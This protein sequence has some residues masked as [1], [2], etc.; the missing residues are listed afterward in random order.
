MPAA[1]GGQL[2]EKKGLGAGGWDSCDEAVTLRV[3]RRQGK[4][5]GADGPPAATLTEAR[6]GMLGAGG[7]MTEPVT[8]RIFSDYV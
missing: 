5:H 1:L 7:L 3:T 8:V 4:A 6:Q 2:R